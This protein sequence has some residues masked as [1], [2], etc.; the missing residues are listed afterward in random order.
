MNT[1]NSKK[2]VNSEQKKKVPV[3]STIQRRIRDEICSERD[4]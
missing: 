1:G 2:I 3:F 4:Q